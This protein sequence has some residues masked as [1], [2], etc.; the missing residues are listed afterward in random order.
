M[1]YPIP[2]TA[3]L[4]TCTRCPLP[5][6]ECN[7]LSEP[8]LSHQKRWKVCFGLDCSLNG[9]ALDFGR[10]PG[11]QRFYGYS[12]IHRQNLDLNYQCCS[13]THTEVLKYFCTNQ[14]YINYHT[15]SFLS[16]FFLRCPTCSPSHTLKLLYI[17]PCIIELKRIILSKLVIIASYL[18]YTNILSSMARRTGQQ[19]GLNLVSASAK[20][21]STRLSMAI[22]SR[23][24][25]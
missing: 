16:I 11:L 25:I 4:N 5:T 23:K 22:C 18:H 19:L 17:F 21:L 1:I 10:K 24:I 6:C 13:Q 14:I 8:R 7:I 3:R 12:I 2:G 9:A 15:F 20:T